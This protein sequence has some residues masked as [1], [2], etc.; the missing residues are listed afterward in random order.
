MRKTRTWLR[1]LG[2]LALAFSLV[3]IAEQF[4]ESQ[5][6]ERALLP[7]AFEHLDH[8]K[9]PCAQ[10]HHN[11]VDNTGGGS[12]YSC[13]KFTP[14]IAPAIEKMFHDFCFGCHVDKREAGEE[15]GPMRECQGCHQQ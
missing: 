5:A 9:T 2:G 1:V 14:E 4:R 7:V 10:C 12:C 3:M 11:F 15:S 13:H 6:P 8:K